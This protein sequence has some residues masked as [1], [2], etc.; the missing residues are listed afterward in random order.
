MYQ[1]AEVDKQP[2][3]AIIDQLCL[4]PELIFNGFSTSYV[5]GFVKDNLL[6]KF[7]YLS[8]PR[9]SVTQD[10]IEQ[11]LKLMRKTGPNRYHNFMK[12][13][14]KSKPNIKVIV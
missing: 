8:K 5:D 1:E 11:L 13:Q 2:F 7:Q 4:K 9:D 6:G 12:D 14:A 3:F 10:D